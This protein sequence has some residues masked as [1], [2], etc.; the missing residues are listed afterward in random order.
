MAVQLHVNLLPHR[1]ERRERLKRLFFAMV[2]VSFAV[3]IGL[4]A[5]GWAVLEGM[6]G[7]Q[8]AR[9]EFISAENRKLEAQIREIAS[10]RQDIEALRARQRAVEDLQADRAQP[11]VLFDQLN[12]QTPDGV[13]LRTVKQDGIKVAIT[14]LAASPERV[15]EFMRNLQNNSP[16]VTAPELVESKIVTQADKATGRQL[17]EFAMNFQL[18]SAAGE[19][20]AA[21]PAG[22]KPAPATRPAPAAKPTAATVKEQRHG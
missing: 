4:V 22:A 1:A 9:N 20:S 6:V 14:G 3:G 5:L 12:T 17:V 8:R 10:L 18:R 11:V 2:G 21:P 15:S 13:Y 19:P 16:Y 7:A